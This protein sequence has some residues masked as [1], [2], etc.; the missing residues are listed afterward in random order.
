MKNKDVN[1]NVLILNYEM[2]TSRDHFILKS[3]LS[4][5]IE[6][7]KSHWPHCDKSFLVCLTII[8]NNNNGYDNN[9]Y[10]YTIRSQVTRDYYLKIKDFL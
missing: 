7:F 9:N 2:E 1:C 10:V 4:H 3:N 5:F 8:Y 6:E